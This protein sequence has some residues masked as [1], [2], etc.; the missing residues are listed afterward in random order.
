MLALI[1]TDTM[2]SKSPLPSPQLLE[3]ELMP[4][5]RV[6]KSLPDMVAEQL[7]AAIHNGAFEPGERLKEEL[8][9]KNFEVSRSTVREAIAILERKG[10]VERIARQGARVISIDAEEI[11]EIFLI[12]AQ[13]LGLAAKLFATAATDERVNEFEQH[14]SRLTRLADDERTTPG[15]YGE[16][17]IKAQQ[18]LIS[19]ASRKRLQDLYEALSDAT[20]W[21]SVVRGRAISFTTSARRKESAEDWR[22]VAAAIR[23]R[24]ADAAEAHAKLVLL[25]SYDAA[26][27]SLL[28]A[29]HK[30]HYRHPAN[31]AG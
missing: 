2:T 21:R 6:A 31:D 10:L 30:N 1:L 28:T 4:V 12:R 3:Q 15:D 29:T 17:S 20:L 24:D 18:Y 11:E 27:D 26:K 19:H 22:R 13:L 9:A 8:L 5:G 7:F 16:A 23:S 25:R 14:I